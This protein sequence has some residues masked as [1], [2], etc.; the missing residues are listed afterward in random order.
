M[1]VTLTTHF[2]SLY[3]RLNPYYSPLEDRD[4]LSVDDE[5]AVLVGD[6]SVVAAVGGVVLKHVDLR[7]ATLQ[8][9]KTFDHFIFITFGNTLQTLHNLTF[10]GTFIQP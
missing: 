3:M 2:N 9:F 6:L 1:I 7:T 10:M 4:G 5:L 8:L